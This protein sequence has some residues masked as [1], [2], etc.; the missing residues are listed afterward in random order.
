MSKAS[1][2]FTVGDIGGKHDIKELKLELDRFRGVNSVSIDSHNKYVMVDFDT[3]GVEPER[4][5][6]KIEALGF[7]VLNVRFEN[8]V[9]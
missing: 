1:A 6:N 8:H 9:M 5:Q 2:C 4:I 7:D 3:T